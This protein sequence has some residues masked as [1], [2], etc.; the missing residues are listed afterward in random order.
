MVDPD[1]TITSQFFVSRQS[2]LNLCQGNHYQFDTL[3]RAKHSSMMVLWHMHNPEAPAFVHHCNN[4]ADPIT[5]GFRW[6]CSLCEDFDL[7]GKCYKDHNHAHRLAPFP[8][9]STLSEE[10]QRVMDEVRRGWG[11][12]V[13]RLQGVV[14]VSCTCST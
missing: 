7:C 6:N 2:F 1:A 5:A 11:L 10:E 3:R 13:R 14:G 12:L 9:T 4:C 8:V